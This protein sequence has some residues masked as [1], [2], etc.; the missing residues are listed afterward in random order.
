MIDLRADILATVQAILKKHVPDAEVRVFGSRV[1]GK[2]KKY[3]DLDLAICGPR[4]L[5]LKTMGNLR[6]AFEESNIPIRVDFVDWN[7]ISDEFR[8]VINQKFELIQTGNKS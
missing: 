4:K 7:T 5:D 2:V 8:E 3:S 6:E 1:T